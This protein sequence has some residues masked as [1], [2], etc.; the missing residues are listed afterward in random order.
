MDIIEEN[1]IKPTIDISVLSGIRY[2]IWGLLKVYPELSFTELAKKLGKS[3]STI[4]PHLQKLIELGIVEISKKEHI[5]ANIEAHYYSLTPDSD[6]IT[7]V[8]GCDLSHGLDKELVKMMA[9]SLKS[10]VLNNKKI[11]D[12][13]IK[14]FEYIE[15]TGSDEIIKIWKETYKTKDFTEDDIP[16]FF[17]GEF[18]LTEDQWMR[19]QN[20]FVKFSMD[21][22]EQVTKEQKENPN[23]EKYIYWFHMGIPVKI[24][25]EEMELEN[26]SNKE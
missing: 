21:F 22:Q 18:F 7:S 24:L 25:F 4:H 15:E 14:F 8:L 11:L 1:Q 26:F 13:Y 12:K 5:R 23:Q 9:K 19:W 10:L 3:K 6:E 20:Q 2:R 16:Q 17:M